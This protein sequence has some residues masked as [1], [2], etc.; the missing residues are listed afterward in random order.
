[1]DYFKEIV[2]LLK[3]LDTERLKCA[4]IFIKGMLD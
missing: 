2:F 3:R 1:M 4:Y